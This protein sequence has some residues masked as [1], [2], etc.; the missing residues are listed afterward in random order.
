[1]WRRTRR[2][3]RTHRTVLPPTADQSGKRTESQVHHLRRNESHLL[4]CS[5]MEVRHSKY[6][7]LPPY[8]ESTSNPKEWE[9]TA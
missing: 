5:K 7:K 2:T 9:L 4:R 1:M 6:L 8:A 3:H